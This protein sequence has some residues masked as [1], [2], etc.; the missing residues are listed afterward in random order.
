[1]ITVGGVSLWFL[2]TRWVWEIAERDPK[3]AGLMTA[4]WCVL[5]LV[6]FTCGILTRE[7]VYRWLGLAVLT[8]SLARVVS[9]DVWRIEQPI[10]RVLSFMA[11]GVVL[12]VL[13][14]VYNKYQEKIR[15]WL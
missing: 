7:R 13:G 8:C 10:Y 3:L 2:V 9:S 6:L 1:V 14:F 15:Q 11:L 5:A 4:S 12:L